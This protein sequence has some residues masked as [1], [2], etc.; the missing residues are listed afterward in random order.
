MTTDAPCSR[1]RRTRSCTHLDAAHHLDHDVG[2]GRQG[3]V[4]ALRPGDRLGH[5][6]DPLARD[7][8]I[9]DVRQ[10]QAARQFA[11]LD[12]NP[13]DRRADGAE[14]EERDAQRSGGSGCLAAVESNVVVCAVMTRLFLLSNPGL[15]SL[16]RPRW[17]LYRPAAGTSRQD[18][19]SVAPGQLNSIRRSP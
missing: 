13:R 8:A 3:L 19:R 9:E 17:S 10:L 11:A 16:S 7:V 6:V 5:P 14:A 18:S 1:A 2:L 15:A 12:Q 4:H